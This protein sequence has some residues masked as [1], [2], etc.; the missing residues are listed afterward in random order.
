MGGTQPVASRNY[1]LTELTDPPP[2][3]SNTDPCAP[4]DPKTC[5]DI[6]KAFSKI[7]FESDACIPD[8]H[9]ILLSN[10]SAALDCSLNQLELKPTLCPTVSDGDAVV[11]VTLKASPSCGAGSGAGPGPGAPRPTLVTT[12]GVGEGRPLFRLLSG[13]AALAIRSLVIDCGGGARTAIAAA[14]GHGVS[15]SDTDFIDCGTDNGAAV[16]LQRGTPLKIHGGAFLDS[17]GAGG[18]SAAAGSS[19]LAAAVSIESGGD[20]TGT[21]LSATGTRFVGGAGQISIKKTSPNRLKAVCRGCQFADNAARGATCVVA[22]RRDDGAA[23]GRPGRPLTLD[24]VKSVF[25]GECGCVPRPGSGAAA[26]CI[27]AAGD[28]FA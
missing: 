5:N 10:C 13:R 21:L 16:A 23:G 6:D 17:V 11:S 24:L 26:V 1:T 20:A 18:G 9:T 25:S 14:A 27:L 19:G 7:A 22:S 15:L 4:K 8:S 12:P 3:S 2:P 28:R